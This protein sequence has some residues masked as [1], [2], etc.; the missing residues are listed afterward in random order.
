MKADKNLNF[1]NGLTCFPKGVWEILTDLKILMYSLIPMILGLVITYFSFYYGWDY[2]QDFV[3]LVLKKYLP[4]W[5]SEKN[6]IYKS[7]FWILDIFTKFIFSI[8]L[9]YISFILVQLISIPFYSLICER[10]LVKRNVFPKRNFEFGTWFR[11]YLRLLIISI[12]RMIILL[13]LG[14]FVFLISFIPG[15]QILTLIFTGYV[16]SLDCLDYTLEIYEV[17]LSRRFYIYFTE[18]G[19]FMGMSVILLPT[20]FIPGLTLIFLPITVVGSAVCYAEIRGPYEYEKLI[21]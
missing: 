11:L 1:Y 8:V 19:F 13:I 3:N 14:V 20:L 15:L 18:V 12:F 4:G 5:I 9:I 21:A 2:T 16:M 6:Y 7:L 17:S 10:V